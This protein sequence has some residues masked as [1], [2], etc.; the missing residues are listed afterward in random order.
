MAKI[1]VARPP[2]PP[3]TCVGAACAEEMTRLATA[4]NT[5]PQTCTAKTETCKDVCTLKD[6]ICKN[7]GRI[8]ELAS[9]LGGTDD[10]AND[11]CNQGNAS[12]TAATQRCCGC[13]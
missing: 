2:A 9:Q 13:L 8:C 7:A 11:K 4:I 3:L 5:P 12:C 10:N 1:E 6:S